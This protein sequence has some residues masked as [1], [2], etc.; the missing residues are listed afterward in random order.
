MAPRARCCAGGV[1]G[2]GAPDGPALDA[3]GLET[4]QRKFERNSGLIDGSVGILAVFALMVAFVYRDGLIVLFAAWLIANMRMAALSAGWDAHLLGAGHSRRLVGDGAR[5]DHRGFLHPDSCRLHAHVQARAEAGRDAADPRIRALVA[6]SASGSR[7]ATALSD[8]PPDHLGGGDCRRCVVVLPALPRYPVHES[9]MAMW[10]AA[11]HAV[12]LGIILS[13]NVYEIAA[14][15]LGVTTA[16]GSVN[17]ITSAVFSSLLVA[18]A[19]A[20]HSYEARTAGTSGG[21][22]WLAAYL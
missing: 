8:L 7:T 4:A 1:R 14:A 15:A 13:S 20:E 5:P 21:S 2:S 16:A 19:I 22:G 17:S 3:T 6:D 10:Y 11:A 9:W 12:L 18:V